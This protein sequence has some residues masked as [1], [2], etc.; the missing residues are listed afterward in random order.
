MPDKDELLF[1]AFA[2]E[3]NLF[4]GAGDQ[5]VTQI[6]MNVQKNE[7]RGPRAAVHMAQRIRQLLGFIGVGRG[8]FVEVQQRQLQ[9]MAD[10]QTPTR[11]PGPD[12]TLAEVG[13]PLKQ[14]HH[15]FFFVCFDHQNGGLGVDQRD[16]VVDLLGGWHVCLQ[17]RPRIRF[18]DGRRGILPQRRLGQQCLVWCRAR[19]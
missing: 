10:T 14:R 17:M 5:G 8:V 13:H 15:A 1:F 2:L 6:G 11:R 16:Q 9:P 19:V 12:L 18:Q 4:D 7:K 3:R